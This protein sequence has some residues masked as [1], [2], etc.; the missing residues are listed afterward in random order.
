MNGCISVSSPGCPGVLAAVFLAN[1]FLCFLS[2][3]FGTIPFCSLVLGLYRRK[4][5]NIACRNY[6]GQR[7]TLGAMENITYFTILYGP[8]L[9]ISWIRPD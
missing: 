8:N 4:G 7:R 3:C 1:W 9:M 6:I 5:L 2:C